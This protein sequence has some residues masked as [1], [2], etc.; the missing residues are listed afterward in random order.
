MGGVDVVGREMDSR[1]WGNICVDVKG[2]RRKD[3]VDG[4]YLKTIA[5]QGNE[6]PNRMTRHRP[7]P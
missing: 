6:T 4:L 2:G 1:N 5:D 7:P 3:E